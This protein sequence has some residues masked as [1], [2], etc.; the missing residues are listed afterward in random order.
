[1]TQS[2]GNI[3][4]LTSTIAPQTGTFALARA[5]PEERL[6]DY[7]Q[8]LEFY[9]P[10]VA[11]GVFDSAVY[12]DNSGYPLDALVE[13]AREHGVADRVE[14]VSYTSDIP[15]EFSRYYLEA[16]LLIEGFERSTRL[17]EAGEASLWKVTGRYIIR[18]IDDIVR[19]QPEDFDLYFNLRN[20][21][22]EI[23]DFFLVGAR[24]R[25]MKTLLMLDLDDFKSK[26]DGEKIL[27]SKIDQG[28]YDDMT[29]I[30]RMRRTPR[31]S[32]VRGFDGAAYDSPVH[33]AKYYLRSAARRLTPWIWI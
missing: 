6:A 9:F 32:G 2:R 5:K 8:S 18:N 7:M 27:R 14:F 30:A 33:T 19:T 16:N 20:R 10:F 25:A 24:A 12:V 15:P 11:T 21:P 1:M 17:R 3:L 4:L 31:L 22:Y 23:V 13:K 26:E 29:L 28:A